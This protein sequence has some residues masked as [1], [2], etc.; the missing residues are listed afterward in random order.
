MTNAGG[1]PA[2][3]TLTP[4][5]P[6]STP[7]SAA[8]AVAT[9]DGAV[10]IRRSAGILQLAR[11]RFHQR[12]LR[13]AGEHDRRWRAGAHE[14]PDQR[15]RRFALPLRAVRA[16]REDDGRRAGRGEDIG[17]ARERVSYPSIGPDCLMSSALPAAIDAALVDERR[18]RAR[19]RARRACARSRRRAGRRRGWRRQTSSAYS[20]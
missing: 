17:G 20:N 3:T 14:L 11:D 13:G 19:A 18:P 12:H 7:A 10:P 8:T 4:V 2:T 9:A 5:R 16:I 15:E 6:S 1:R